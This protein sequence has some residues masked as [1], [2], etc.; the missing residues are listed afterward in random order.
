MDAGRRV[1]TESRAPSEREF[2][3]GFQ[4]CSRPRGQRSVPSTLRVEVPWLRVYVDV[5]LASGSVWCFCS[6]MWFWGEL[7][8][9]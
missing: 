1:A 9:F 5:H 2:I 7:F 3:S 8:H 4:I 6:S